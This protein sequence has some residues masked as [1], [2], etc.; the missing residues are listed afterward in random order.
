MVE[1]ADA[2][3]SKSAVLWAWGFE[4]LYRHQEE[5]KVAWRNGRRSSLRGCREQSRGGSNPLVTTRR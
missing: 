3:D 5:K 4:S 1:L 2:V